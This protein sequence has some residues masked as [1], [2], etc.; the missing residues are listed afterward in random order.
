MINKNKLYFQVD[1]VIPIITEGYFK[2][3]ENHDLFSNS[4]YLD[5]KYTKYISELMFANY[6]Q[7]SC[8]NYK[9]RCLIPDNFKNL[10]NTHPKLTD[11]LFSVWILGKEI[12]SFRKHILKG[13]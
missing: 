8:I 9:V 10:L 4:S 3:L 7:S 1:Y 11:P 5:T 13:F 12:E 2:S 6:I